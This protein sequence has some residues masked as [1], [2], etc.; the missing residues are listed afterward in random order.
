M[1]EPTPRDRERNDGRRYRLLGSNASPYA[2]KI[3]ALL[4]Y[5]RIPHD[6]IIMNRVWRQRVATVRPNLIPFLQY[7]GETGWHTD[8]TTMITALE[9][10]HAGRTV[11]P[12]DPAVRFLSELL[13]DL[14]D[15]WAVKS[16]FIYRWSD[17]ADQA[18][19]GR[20]G[21]YEWGTSEA[22][23]GS[24][25]AAAEFRDRQIGRMPIIGAAGENFPL[26]EACYH[27]TIDAFEGHV[28]M[29]R[30]LFGSRPSAAD[31]A[32]YG[33]LTQLAIDPTPM[34]VMRARGPKTDLWRRWVDDLSGL[35]GDWWPLETV[36]EGAARGLLELAGNVYLPFLAANAAA[37]RAGEDTVALSLRGMPYRQ[38]V[39]RFQ[40][41]CLDRLRHLF[42]TLD[43]NARNRLVPVLRECGCWD[44]LTAEETR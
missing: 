23:A 27:D 21:G 12:P 25:E 22:P 30:F 31:I 29:D 41:K 34:A 38:G 6:W 43:P 28:A 18:Y 37:Y 42:E 11:L 17:P 5:R 33:Q 24:D 15:E 1:P 40:V 2:L 13:E 14:A 3:R 19:V 8:S 32:W 39:F 44:H 10:R 7:P 36:L 35:E 26:L 9:N 20:W 4:R 16:L